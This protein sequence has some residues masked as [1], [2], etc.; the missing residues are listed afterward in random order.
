MAK[1]NG[2]D[3]APRGQEYRSGG[4]DKFDETAPAYKASTPGTM[5]TNTT[6]MGTTGTG[7]TGMPGTPSGTPII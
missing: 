2:V 3:A 7:T 1:Y 6:G 4:W 5:S